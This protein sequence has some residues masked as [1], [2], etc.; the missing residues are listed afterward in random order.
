MAVKA[1][2]SVKHMWLHMPLA[3]ASD[4][5]KQQKAAAECTQETED[6]GRTA[7]HRSTTWSNYGR[8]RPPCDKSLKVSYGTNANKVSLTEPVQLLVVCCS[9]R[10]L[11]NE[12]ISP[13]LL[14]CCLL[15]N[16]GCIMCIT[17]HT[18]RL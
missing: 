3:L 17:A 9:G 1:V 14:Q 13:V 2:C 18:V 4:W 10:A 8:T 15:A 12:L 6:P 5:R 11:M 16:A 7:A